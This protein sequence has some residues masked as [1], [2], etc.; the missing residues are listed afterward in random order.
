MGIANSNIITARPAMAFLL[1]GCTF[2][3]ASLSEGR[4]STIF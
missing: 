4:N 1:S 3:S 2:I